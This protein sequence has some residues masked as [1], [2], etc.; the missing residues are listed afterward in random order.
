MVFF[1]LALDFY[2]VSFFKLYECCA[3]LA[4]QRRYGTVCGGTP[5]TVYG[6]MGSSRARLTSVSDIKVRLEAS[7]QRL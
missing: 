5:S 1:P 4:V 7:E 3:A 2:C 6:N